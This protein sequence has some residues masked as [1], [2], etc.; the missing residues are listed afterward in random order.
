M[1]EQ[2]PLEK[3]W[4]ETVEGFLSRHPEYKA[5]SPLHAS[6]DHMVKAIASLPGAEYLGP[7]DIITLAYAR[8]VQVADIVKERA[9]RRAQLETDILKHLDK[10]Q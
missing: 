7:V 6:F 3:E 8:M 2:N 4:R 10:Y 1:T 5:G 9:Q